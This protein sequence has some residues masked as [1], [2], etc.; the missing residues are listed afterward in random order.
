MTELRPVGRIPSGP[1]EHPVLIDVAGHERGQ[2]IDITC[3]Q[4]RNPMAS[5]IPE[6]SDKLSGVSNHLYTGHTSTIA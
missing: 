5:F 1:L 3:R 2:E 4:R 6:D